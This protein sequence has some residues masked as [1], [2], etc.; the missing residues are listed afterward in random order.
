MIDWGDG[1]YE[2]TA[3]GIA[4]AATEGIDA[5]APAAGERLLDLGCGT[6]NAAILAA[7]RGAKVVAID[8]AARLVDVTAARAKS[9]GL[10]IDAKVGDAGAIPSGDASV[11]ALVSIFAVIFAP[12]AARATDEMVRVVRPG[13]RIVITTWLPTG[14]IAAAGNILRAAMAPAD[15]P[16][17]PPPPW[18]DESAVR[19][20]F[21]SRGASVEL[22]KKTIHFESTSAGGWFA[23]QVENHPVWR[24]VNRALEATPEKWADVRKRSIEALEAGNLV[25]DGYRAAS[26]YLVVKA[27]RGG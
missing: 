12:D 25:K 15:A 7:K 17:P 3:K 11:D 14:P 19:A 20:L 1:H 18:G 9:E 5:L 26:D 8:P 13:G 27:V 23:E 22:I 16:S 6:G 2:L 4:D 24:F 21:E 10:D